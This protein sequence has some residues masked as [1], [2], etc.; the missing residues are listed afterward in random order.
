VDRLETKVNAMSKPTGIMDNGKGTANTG[1]ASETAQKIMN[2]MTSLKEV[3]GK[4]FGKTM[5]E[6]RNLRNQIL[7]LVAD[8]DNTTNH[9]FKPTL[10]GV[11]RE[12]K[13]PNSLAM[14]VMQNQK[15]IYVT[16]LPASQK[17]D[18]LIGKI[19]DIKKKL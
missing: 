7:S 14:K 17:I 19:K 6:K 1:T 15:R 10:D 2:R 11:A 8:L 9:K 4:D 12:L 18:Q 13:D 16:T 5:V 3:S